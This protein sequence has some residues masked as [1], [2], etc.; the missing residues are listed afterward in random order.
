MKHNLKHTFILLSLLSFCFG[1][2]IPSWYLDGKLKG[3]S[4]QKYFVG[5]G[6]GKDY[7]KALENAGL[8]I[9]SQMQISISSK[10]ES[11]EYC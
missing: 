9:A 5:I 11:I 1:Q 7:Q 2:K 6:E 3:Y 4:P 10:L 8:Y